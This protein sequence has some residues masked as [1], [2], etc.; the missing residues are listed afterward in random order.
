[1]VEKL[2][3]RKR[4]LKDVQQQV[5]SESDMYQEMIDDFE[6]QI[7]EYRNMIKNL[8]EL[9]SGYKTVI[10]AN[11]VKVSQAEREVADVINTLVNKKE[12]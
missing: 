4:N 1:M 12:F 3:E 5:Q 10:H 6:T 9:C 11:C 2:N 8:E 7:K